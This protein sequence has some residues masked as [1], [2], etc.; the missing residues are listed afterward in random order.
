MLALRAVEGELRFQV[1]KLNLWR[2]WINHQGEKPE[3]GADLARIISGRYDQILDPV[4]VRR[5]LQEKKQ[6]DHVP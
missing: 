3:V 1:L 4:Q 5:F 2:G 6:V